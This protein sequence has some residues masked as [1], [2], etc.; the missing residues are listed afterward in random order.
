TVELK[1]V[2]ATSI[3]RTNGKASL[4]IS[5]TASPDGNAVKISD[6]VRAK[7]ADLRQQLGGD[8]AL[9]PVFDQAPFVKKSVRSLSTEGALGLLFAVIVILIFLVSLR[10]TLVTA[11][12]IPLSVVVALIGLWLGEYSLNLLTLGA[13]TIAV[14]RV[15]DDSIVVLENIKRHMEYGEDKRHAILTGVREVT[16]AVVAS[17]LTTVAVFLPIGLV[18]GLAGELFRPFAITITVALAASLLVALT[19]VPVLAYWFLRRPK[20]IAEGQSDEV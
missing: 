11:V 13:L 1:T 8:A 6:E 2:D 16:G 12:S 17:T 15:V 3:T 7:L 18:G 10:S 19:V 14:G 5:V 9:T 4:G 20:H